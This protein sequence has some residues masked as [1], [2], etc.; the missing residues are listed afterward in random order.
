MYRASD[1]S[2]KVKI[3]ARRFI[4]FASIFI[5]PFFSYIFCFVL[6]IILLADNL[7]AE[8]PL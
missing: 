7:L 6:V 2:F 1:F 3:P 8:N 4:S 5:L